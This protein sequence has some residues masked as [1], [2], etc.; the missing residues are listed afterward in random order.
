MTAK[1]PIDKRSQA[2]T[3]LHFED[4]FLQTLLGYEHCQCQWKQ[5]REKNPHD[6]EPGGYMSPCICG[7]SMPLLSFTNGNIEMQSSRPA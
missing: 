2:A 3:E 7:P 6:S 4:I 5:K 1:K